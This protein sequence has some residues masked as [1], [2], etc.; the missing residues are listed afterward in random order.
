M[1]T[2]DKP[3][4]LNISTLI[5]KNPKNPLQDILVTGFIGSRESNQLRCICLNTVCKEWGVLVRGI[6]GGT[7]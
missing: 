1:F 3:V 4:C 5:F 2:L 6:V 7:A